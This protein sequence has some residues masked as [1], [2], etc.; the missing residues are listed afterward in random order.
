MQRRPNRAR[1]SLSKGRA[2]L[3]RT[4]TEKEAQTSSTRT[5][6]EHPARKL[7]GKDA[8]VG[9]TISTI[10]KATSKLRN[11][12]EASLALQGPP[13][14]RKWSDSTEITADSSAK[15]TT[16]SAKTFEN[17]MTTKTI[18]TTIIQ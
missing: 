6:T 11:R 13:A 14:P 15:G 12:T 8:N 10:A 17:K 3:L 4:Q 2:L 9:P 1:P 7:P 5:H 16:M 18:T